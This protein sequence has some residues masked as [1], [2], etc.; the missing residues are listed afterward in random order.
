MAR[1][2]GA[3]AYHY[4]ESQDQP[5]HLRTIGDRILKNTLYPVGLS[6]HHI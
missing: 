1:K 5:E 2:F 6:D 3:I 4:W